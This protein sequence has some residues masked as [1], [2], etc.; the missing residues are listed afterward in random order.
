MPGRLVA[1]IIGR[2]R[3]SVAAKPCGHGRDARALVCSLELEPQTVALVGQR[4]DLAGDL[5]EQV[6]GVDRGWILCSFGLL[7]SLVRQMVRQ[8]S[9][10]LFGNAICRI[11]RMARNRPSLLG[12]CPA[13]AVLP[14]CR[15][16][17]Q[18]ARPIRDGHE[19]RLIQNPRRHRRSSTPTDSSRASKR[20]DG[21]SEPRERH[22]W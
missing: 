15:S 20:C 6:H 9:A 14:V 12:F 11:C 18:F 4:A 7:C 22:L 16:V 8:T 10:G 2:S 19:P 5:L 17:R 3:R 13:D 1:R 21:S